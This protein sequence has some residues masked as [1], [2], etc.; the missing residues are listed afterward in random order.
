MDQRARVRSG[1]D[2][3]LAVRRGGSALQAELAEGAGHAEDEQ[4]LGLFRA[5]PAERESVA[6]QELAAAARARIGADRNAGGAERVEV[7]VDR[8]D[9]HLELA[10][11]VR[12]GRLSA[13]LKQQN[14]ADQAVGAHRTQARPYC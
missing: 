5:Q 9:R 4:G 3:D 11:E 1:R 14:Q 13:G 12:G 6:V 2:P 7:P 8:P 10:G